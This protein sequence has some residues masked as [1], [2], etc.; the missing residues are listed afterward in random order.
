MRFLYITKYASQSLVTTLNH[1]RFLLILL[2]Y[3]FD[4][5]FLYPAIFGVISLTGITHNWTHSNVIYRYRIWSCRFLLAH[6][7]SVAVTQHV[8]HFFWGDLSTYTHFLCYIVA[9][10]LFHCYLKV[11]YLIINP[12]NTMISIFFSAI[13]CSTLEYSF[14]SF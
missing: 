3:C 8:S 4:F 2:L 10:L 12:I 1:Y 13:V 14:N 11:N 6:F 9:P 5:F 7:V